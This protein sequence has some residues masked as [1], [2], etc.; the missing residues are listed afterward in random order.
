MESLLFEIEQRLLV[1]FEE[2]GALPDERR[3]LLSPPRRQGG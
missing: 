1:A 2:V 3:S